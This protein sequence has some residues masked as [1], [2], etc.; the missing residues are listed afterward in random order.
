M[1]L[2]LVEKG[3]LKLGNLFKQK[4]R[5]YF[6]RTR[7]C[8]TKGRRVRQSGPPHQR[9]RLGIFNAEDFA[10]GYVTSQIY[11]QIE[12]PPEFLSINT[13]AYPTD[14]SLFFSPTQQRTAANM[15][16]QHG[17]R[18]NEFGAF[19]VTWCGTGEY[20]NVV[21]SFQCFFRIIYENNNY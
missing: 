6:L 17:M 1:E 20:I 5:V 13:S 19:K 12:P 7:K 2:N 16:R 9:V 15:T 18:K 21:I 10:G 8:P 11:P 4:I 3:R 14:D